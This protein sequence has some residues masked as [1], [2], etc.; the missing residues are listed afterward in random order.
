MLLFELLPTYLDKKYLSTFPTRPLTELT[1][2]CYWFRTSQASD[3]LG[4]DTGFGMEFAY[5]SIPVCLGFS[6]PVL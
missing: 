1:G 5:L 2:L 3:Q 4:V 6:S